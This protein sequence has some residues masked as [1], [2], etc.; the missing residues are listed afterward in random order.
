MSDNDLKNGRNG[1]HQYNIEI[2]PP[3]PPVKLNKD[4]TPAK[5]QPKP[6]RP[7]FNVPG[8]TTIVGMLDKPGLAWGAAKETAL[9]AVNDQ[10][11]WQR[12]PKPEAVELVRTHFRRVWDLKAE[13]GT[14]VHEVALTW[15]RGQE[16]DLE[17]LLALDSKGRERTW[18][19]DERAEVQRRVIGCVDALELFYLEQRP[20]WRYTE[21]TVVHP[22]SGYSPEKPYKVDPKTA[23]A[24][25]FDGDGELREHGPGLWDFKT[26]K[27]YPT[28][29]TL[30]VAG[31]YAH[32]PLLGHYADD[33]RLLSVEPYEAPPKRGSIW[34]HDDG[35]Y[36]VLELPNGR[37]PYVS[38]MRLRRMH[39][40]LAEM[41]KWEKEHPD[42]YAETDADSGEMEPETLAEALP[43]TETKEAA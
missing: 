29:V 39:A 26:G 12:L 20:K 23:Y 19:A 13:T 10:Q 7:K 33:G 30:Q 43:K 40:D 41:R 24:G 17:K 27:R 38:F 36:E 37:K 1:N 28:E 31:G 5:I 25:C 8:V 6:T 22:Y 16:A 21:Q 18:T 34:L 32:A 15:A 14:I 2:A 11:R 9:L 3:L 4:G 35:T 42:P